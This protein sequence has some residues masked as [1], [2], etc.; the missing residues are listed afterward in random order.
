MLQAPLPCCVQHCVVIKALGVVIC[1]LL[2]LQ[3][4]SLQINIAY[5][6]SNG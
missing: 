3:E 6:H 5:R 4:M 2:W 1:Y